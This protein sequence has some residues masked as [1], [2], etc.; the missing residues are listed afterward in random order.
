MHSVIVHHHLYQPPREDP[1]LEVVPTEPSA[2]PDHDWNARIN[3]ECY[4]R[5]AAAEAHLRD[6]RAAERDPDARAGI[7]RV[8]NLYAWC[9]FDVGA[10]LCEWLDAEA[11]ETM[12]AM[13]DGDAASVRRWGV[14]NAIAAPYHHVILPLASPR[15]RR[16]EIRWGIRDF[17]RRFRREPQ[18]MWLPECAADEDT[19][20]AV[21]A[22]GIAFT[23]LAPYQVHGH[24]GGGMPVRWRGT[25]GRSLTI[26][27]YD[28]SLAGDVAFG[29]LLR[30]ARALAQRLSPAADPR[31]PHPR[32]TMLAT[33]GETFGHHHKGGDSTLT[34]ALAMV[35]QQARSRVTNVAALV[36]RYPATTDVQLVSP[37]AWS[38][39]HGVER[40]RS[41][42]GCRLDGHKAPA[43]QWRGPLRAA[44]Q[45]LANHAHDVFEREGAALFV[46]DPWLVRDRYGDVVAQDGDA[47]EQFARRELPVDASDHQVQR[48]RELLELARATMRT[49]TSCAWFFDEVDR[50]EVR[51][52]LRYA[53]RAIELTGYASRLT[54]ELVQWLA[55]ATS[56]AP[57]AGSASELFVREA[58]PHRD[59]TTCVAA[60]AIACAAMGIAAPRIAIF[61]VATVRDA[62]VEPEGDAD[63]NSVG[64]TS[65]HAFAPA[66]TTVPVRW[67]VSL[68]HRRT[69]V[70]RTFTGHLHGTGPGLAVHLVEGDISPHAATVPAG[71][72]LEVNIHEFPEAIARQILRPMA[73]S[74]SALLDEVGTR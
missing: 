1:W 74:E 19:L 71:A 30:D 35:M 18:G 49:F 41:N 20:D 52:V 65:V 44:L 48:A 42:C 50:I 13:Q 29:G 21:A 38:C 37:S 61:D 5:L 73:L 45:R 67:H 56:G 25:A 72:A 69:G 4:A 55:P 8:V 15:E 66:A 53:A 39:A 59:A 14:G 40:W 24:H 2:A 23:I 70:I 51:Q 6:P 32:C 64:D 11:P 58:L 47:I 9:S 62:A 63:A 12:A 57:D 28:G 34:E 36:A 27:P 16:T 10:T 3:R 43:Q 7:A 26:V 54:P 68:S 22:E 31:D 33:D 17:R 46:D 60:G